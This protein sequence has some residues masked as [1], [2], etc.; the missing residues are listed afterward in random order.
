M[1]YLFSNGYFY[2]RTKKGYRKLELY[3]PASPGTYGEPL[4]VTRDRW[5]EQLHSLKG[6]IIESGRIKKVNH[7][8]NMIMKAEISLSRK[9]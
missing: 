2:R 8:D 1:I 4:R 6:C 9:S 7:A 3:L 5:L